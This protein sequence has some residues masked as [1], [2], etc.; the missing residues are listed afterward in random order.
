MLTLTCVY[1]T[2]QRPPIVLIAR[3]FISHTK[4]SAVCGGILGLRAAGTPTPYAAH[5]SLVF[6]PTASKRHTHAPFNLNKHSRLTTIRTLHQ[7]LTVQKNCPY[8]E[9]F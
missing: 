2:W 5:L 9:T 4:C 8:F 3:H 6:Y 1:S 7:V